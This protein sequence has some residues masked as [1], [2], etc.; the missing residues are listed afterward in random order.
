[1]GSFEASCCWFARTLAAKSSCIVLISSLRTAR[2]QAAI[3][4]TLARC[5]IREIF[6]QEPGRPPVWH[7]RSIPELLQCHPGKPKP[8]SATVHSIDSTKREES[9]CGGSRHRQR[10][11]QIPSRR[12]QCAQSLPK[13]QYIHP[14]FH[15]Y[16]STCHRRGRIRFR[17]PNTDR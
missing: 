8:R 17:P 16:A 2:N 13:Q 1:V 4:M 7:W 9:L 10:D 14:L 12:T 6:Q 11:Y 15:E 3:K 5:S